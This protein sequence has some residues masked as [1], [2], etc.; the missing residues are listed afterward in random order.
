MA[1]VAFVGCTRDDHLAAVLSA[2]AARWLVDDP[3]NYEK[4]TEDNNSVDVLSR[5]VWILKDLS[6]SYDY[7]IGITGN[8]KKDNTYMY[9]MQF[10]S[11][12]EKKKTDFYPTKWG[13]FFNI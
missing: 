5:I 7:C 6:R 1:K 11:N 10:V 3:K 13:I 12:W 8:D 9:M 4:E 2:C